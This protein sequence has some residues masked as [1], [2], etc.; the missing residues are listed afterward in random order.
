MEQKEKRVKSCTKS[1]RFM[2]STNITWATYA[3]CGSPK[4]KMQVM[5]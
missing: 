2:E 3:F 1:L 4:E 5:I